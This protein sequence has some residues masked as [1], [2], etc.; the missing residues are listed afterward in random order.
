MCCGSDEGKAA[1]RRRRL[2]C[3]TTA[4]LLLGLPAALSYIVQHTLR[5]ALLHSS[6][7][8]SLGPARHST[9]SAS[10]RFADWPH[11]LSLSLFRRVVFRLYKY[12]QRERERAEYT[13]YMCVCMRARESERDG[14]TLIRAPEEGR[15]EGVSPRVRETESRIA[16]T[17]VSQ[18]SV[19]RCAA[20]AR[21]PHRRRAILTPTWKRPL[22]A[23]IVKYASKQAPTSSLSP[24]PPFA[25]SS[26]SSIA[27]SSSLAP[28][29]F[30]SVCPRI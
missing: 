6:L 25:F 7:S 28:F 24:A 23:V 15:T 26:S 19:S 3:D 18:L 22:A 11:S 20:D 17:L 21:V 29:C 16:H 2:D 4:L 13:I 12:T 9:P 8:L 1:P 10:V 30:A 5:P 14:A 27:P